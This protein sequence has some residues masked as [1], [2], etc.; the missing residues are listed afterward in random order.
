MTPDASSRETL[1]A[2]AHGGNHGRCYNG[3]N[4]RN[5]LPPQD[6]AAS[7]RRWLLYAGEPVH[8]TGSPPR[9]STGLHSQS[10]LK[11]TG[12]YIQ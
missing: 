11:R 12:M 7:P 9:A 1:S 6:R 5:A 10:R 2:V 4:P 8:R 3:G